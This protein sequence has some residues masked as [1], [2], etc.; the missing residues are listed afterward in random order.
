MQLQ[1]QEVTREI[2]GAA[3]EVHNHLGHGFLERVYRNSMQVELQLRGFTCEMERPIQVRYKDVLVG[4]YVADLL[5]NGL[6]IVELKVAKEYN[7]ADEAQLLNELKA[8]GFKVG[9]LINFG[10]ERVDFKRFVW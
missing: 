6:V 9:L 10:R 4:S 5:V 1:R 7:P 3:F 8:T 2:I